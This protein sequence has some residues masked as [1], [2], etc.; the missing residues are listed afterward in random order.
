M[1][2]GSVPPGSVPPSARPSDAVPPGEWT[3]PESSP[4]A[5]IGS[6][7]VGPDGSNPA[8]GWTPPAAAEAPA[9][10]GINISGW[11]IRG[12]IVAA[13]V[14]AGLV[15]RDRLSG[16]A[17]DLK[18]GDCFDD[19][20]AVSEITD[21]QHQPCT[22]AHDS[23]VIF[24]GDYPAQDAYPPDEAFSTFAEQQCVPAFEAYVGRDYETDTEYE[25]GFYYPA[26]ESWSDSDHEV[27][28][29]VYRIDG[30]KMTSSVKA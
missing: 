10:G 23:E 8:V 5:P 11:L 20:G 12:G 13:I 25:F 6:G 22:D 15:F 21:V 7:A 4:A 14:V 27:A 18:V 30:A 17:G 19:P 26:S 2:Q 29:F 28:C 16:N 1:P 9:R 24:V 3:G